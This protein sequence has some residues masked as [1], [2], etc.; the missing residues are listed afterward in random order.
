MI[1]YSEDNIIKLYQ[2]I[3]DLSGSPII[4]KHNCEAVYTP[5][6]VW[7]NII[8]HSNFKPDNIDQSISAIRRDIAQGIYP[9]HIKFNPVTIN[10]EIINKFRKLPLQSGSWAGMTMPLSQE[11]NYQTIDNYTINII[12]RENDLRLW[13][14]VVEPTLLKGGKLDENIIFGLSKNKNVRFMAGLW[15][16]KMVSTAMI[17][18]HQNSAGVYLITTL[19]EFQRKGLGKQITIE[20]LNLAY[21]MG[22][23]HAVLQATPSGLS[24]YQSIGFTKQCE[25]P[26][27]NLA[28]N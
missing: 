14:Q 6:S 25:I 28:S 12:N 13:I 24:V 19:P 17:L 11:T 27:F 10:P 1:G 3:S 22:C 15:N 7:P 21:Q 5:G 26:V 2:L 16:G 23:D 9:K 20:A 8:Y 4:Q 18:K